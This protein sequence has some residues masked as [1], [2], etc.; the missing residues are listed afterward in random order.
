MIQN[1]LNIFSK[2]IGTDVLSKVIESNHH[3]SLQYYITPEYSSLG[4]T[5][6]LFIKYNGELLPL[7][8]DLK[9]LE[10]KMFNNIQNIR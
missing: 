6:L 9:L 5:L 8:T 2:S 1:Y 3:I 10:L 4:S 7:I